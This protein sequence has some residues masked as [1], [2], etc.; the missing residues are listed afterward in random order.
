MDM[1]KGR[2]KRMSRAQFMQARDKKVMIKGTRWAY[3]PNKWVKR[4]RFASALTG[5]AAII[6]IVVAVVLLH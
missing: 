1:E 6:V 4:S 5:I 3:H 2:S